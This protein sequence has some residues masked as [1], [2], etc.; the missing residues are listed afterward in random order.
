MINDFYRYRTKD[1]PGTSPARHRKQKLY[2]KE[3]R[4]VG[5]AVIF[6]LCNFVA[7]ATSLAVVHEYYPVIEPLPGRS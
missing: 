2:P 6:V 7:T 5:V 3:L 4:K 1:L